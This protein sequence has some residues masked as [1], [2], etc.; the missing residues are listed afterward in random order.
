MNVSASRTALRSDVSRATQGP[1]H[2]PVLTPK[3][4]CRPILSTLVRVD[5]GLSH[6]PGVLIPPFG[7]E[8]LT[9]TRLCISYVVTN[10]GSQSLAKH[11]LPIGV[12]IT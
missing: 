10:E 8:L 9:Y 2:L 4:Q 1:D 6:P 12:Q 7:H 3:T 11:L 5:G